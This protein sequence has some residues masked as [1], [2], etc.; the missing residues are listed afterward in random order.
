MIC[1]SGIVLHRFH[2]K[3]VLTVDVSQLLQQ[4]RDQ[5]ERMDRAIAALEELH[6][7]GVNIPISPGRGRRSMGFEERSAV[8]QRM[9][10]YWALRRS[11]KAKETAAT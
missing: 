2:F 8:S 9:K 4:L 10:R 7:A 3:E 5:S 11:K 1:F 6:A